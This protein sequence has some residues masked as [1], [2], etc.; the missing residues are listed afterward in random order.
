[1]PWIYHLV[2]LFVF[3]PRCY[4]VEEKSGCEKVNKLH[5][6]EYTESQAK[7]QQAPNVRDNFNSGIE[8]SPLMDNKV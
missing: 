8:L 6:T 4:Y 7:S 5:K 2:T 3:T 1:M